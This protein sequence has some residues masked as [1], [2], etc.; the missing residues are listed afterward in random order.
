MEPRDVGKALTMLKEH[1]GVNAETLARKLAC[2]I[3]TIAR[4]EEG[5][6]IPTD[7]MCSRVASVIDKEGDKDLW[8]KIG[9]LGGATTGVAMSGAAVTTAASVASTT[10]AG[11]AVM[12][13]GLAGIGGLVGGGM[14]AGLAVVAAVPVATGLAGYGAVKVVKWALSEDKTHKF[15]TEID[16][17]LERRITAVG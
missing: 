17:E 5:R 7:V 14:V 12:T 11:G 3:Y 1:L 8:A 10:V 4:I 9:A 6:T 13:T 15:K 16:P 2:S